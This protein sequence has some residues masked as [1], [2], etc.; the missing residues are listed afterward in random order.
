MIA[1]VIHDDDPFARIRR[2][3]LDDDRI[4]FKAKGI[5]AFLLSKTRDWRPNL[6]HLSR[7]G[8][9]GREAVRSGLDELIKFGYAKRVRIIHR[10]TGQLVRWEMF[11]TSSP[12][13]TAAIPDTV[14]EG[15]A[16]ATNG[17]PTSGKATC[18]KPDATK[19][20]VVRK[21]EGTKEEDAIASSA[22]AGADRDGDT[23]FAGES[24]PSPED[25]AAYM[26]ECEREEERGGPEK[27]RGAE[28][29]PTTQPR[30]VA[31]SVAQPD[32]QGTLDGADVE[33]DTRAFPWREV[34]AIFK[35]HVPEV[36]MPDRGSR[37]DAGIKAFWRKHGKTTGVFGLLAQRVAESDWLMG[38]NGHDG[39]Q[40]RPY[41][42]GWIF[43]KD[44]R[45][46]WR[47]DR[48]MAGDY[49]NDR[50]AFVL[51]KKAK[52]AAA[53]PVLTRVMLPGDR[54][55]TEVDLNE[56]LA[57]GSAR[58]RVVGEHVANGLPEVLDRKC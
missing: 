34:C 8:Q 49:D 9:D 47:C 52:A 24:E 7:V 43:A 2:E 58:F 30:P 46:Q 33:P 19:E 4:S 6:E 50:M 41:S 5:L 44:Q 45:G 40:G 22:T 1:N 23:A 21:K 26:E 12:E 54:K 17:F 38:R 53:G 20:R 57:D 56:K 28:P 10:S 48:I 25:V 36:T 15:E 11:V 35:A 31:A 14:G 32:G 51:E 42:W 18:G 3:I 37:R 27:A 16:I 55:W 13:R 29:A 39:C